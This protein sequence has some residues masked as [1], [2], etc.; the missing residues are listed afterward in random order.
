MRQHA[1]LPGAF[2]RA[3]EDRLQPIERGAFERT[4]AGPDRLA[5]PDDYPTL[6]YGIS[7]NFHSAPS[8]RESRFMGGEDSQRDLLVVKIYFYR[9]L[10]S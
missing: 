10:V 6:C 3:G 7:A 1:H 5:M 9:A 8:A 2:G 4:R